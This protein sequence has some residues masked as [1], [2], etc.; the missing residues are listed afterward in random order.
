LTAC[1]RTMDVFPPVFSPPCHRAG[2]VSTGSTGTIDHL[3]AKL[4][5]NP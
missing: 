3:E 1:G 4:K 5:E 2:E